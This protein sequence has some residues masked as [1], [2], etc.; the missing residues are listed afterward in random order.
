MPEEERF[1]IHRLCILVPKISQVVEQQQ[2]PRVNGSP[3]EDK[4][5][6]VETRVSNEKYTILCKLEIKNFVPFLTN[7]F[8]NTLRVCFQR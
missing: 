4:A 7:L 1:R 8:I 3:A 6:Y 2:E 5:I